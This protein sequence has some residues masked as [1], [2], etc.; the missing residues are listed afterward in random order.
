MVATASAWPTSG[1]L[2]AQTA[3]SATRSEVE[4][5]ELRG[6]RSVPADQ[7]GRI[8]ATRASYCRSWLISPMCRVARSSLFVRKHYFDRAELASD[9]TRL[10]NFYWRRGFR[11]VQVDTIVRPSRRGVVVTFDVREGPPIVVDTL[12][13][14]Q[15]TPVLDTA[16]IQ[17]ALRLR[18]GGLLDL[19]RSTPHSSSWATPCGIP[20][21]R[22]R[23]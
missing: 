11:E 3:G 14:D 16:T 12:V 6:V 18:P 19:S 8:V 20:A 13:V 23:V 17:R 21:M 22:T 15:A 10:R 7:V 4:H 5:V 2:V 9:V 1:G